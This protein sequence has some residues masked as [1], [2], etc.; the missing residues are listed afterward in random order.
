MTGLKLQGIDGDC[1]AGGTTFF[2][3]QFDTISILF[4]TATPLADL[5]S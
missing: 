5:G 1:P 4:V 3:L 2:L